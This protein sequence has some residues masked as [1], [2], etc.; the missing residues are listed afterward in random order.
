TA[1]TTARIESSSV[2]SRASTV[3]PFCSS[4]ASVSGRRAVAYTFHPSCA[5][6]AAVASPMPDEQP[7]IRT[8]FDGAV[9]TATLLRADE[10][11]VGDPLR[12]LGGLAQL[13]APQTLVPLEVALEP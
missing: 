11:L 8:A 13:L 1:S 6:R 12:P 2:T 10:L 5:R 3:H 7:V 4:A 9:T